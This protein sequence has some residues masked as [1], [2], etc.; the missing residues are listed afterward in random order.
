MM[1]VKPKLCRAS[2]TFFIARSGKV[3]AHHVWS[4]WSG[5]S[6]SATS[7]INACSDDTF[8]EGQEESSDLSCS[9]SRWLKQTMR[10][11]CFDSWASRAAWVAMKVFPVPAGPCRST[12]GKL[13]ASSTRSSCSSSAFWRNFSMSLWRR[14]GAWVA[15]NRGDNAVSMA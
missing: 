15:V 13:K 5:G 4:A 9:A 2:S 1:R 10:V 11:L 7:S 6:T 14:T 12:F 8:T 3:S